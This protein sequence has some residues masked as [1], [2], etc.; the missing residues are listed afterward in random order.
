MEKKS[1]VAKNYLYN[2]GLNLL[3]M[4][5]PLIT[6]PYATRVIGAG[7]IGKVAFANSISNYFLMFAGLGISTYAIR[8][9]AKARDNKEKTDKI[10]SEIITINFISTLIFSMLYYS[11]LYM[12]VFRLNQNDKVLFSV[13]GLV[14]VLNFINIDW[15]YQGFEQYKYITIRSLIFKMISLIFLFLMVRNKSDYVWYAALSIIAQSGSNILNVINARKFVSF[16]MHNINLKKHIKPVLIIF[17]MGLAINVYNNLDSTIL[18]VR[19][20]EIYV[21]YYTAAVKIN[22]IVISVVT[23]L[24]VVLLPRLS[25]YIEND[26]EKF[27]SLIRKS[28][29]YVLFITI[30]SCIGLFILAPDIIILFSGNEFKP[31]IECMRINIPVIMFVAIANITSLQILLPL[32]KE[33]L[34]MVT[35]IIAALINLI[36]NFI[37]IPIYKQNGAAFSSCIAE[38]TVT[39]LQIIF[40]R[41]YI[42]KSILNKSNLNYIVGSLIIMIE[43]I[44]ISKL[45][46][47]GLVNLLVSISVSAVTYGIYLLF[48]KDEMLIIILRKLNITID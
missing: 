13:V 7:G 1:S 36:L 34:V 12:N 16:N 28:I 11:S 8:E 23:S 39:I 9:I 10:F 6:F 37:F 29:K 45:Q 33:K 14:L 5:F 30:P 32:R 25:Y 2:I 38:M 24:G 43:L 42:S 4:L 48:R 40:C 19:A 3:T 21:G 22:R 15:L 47:N 31:A 18:G 20:G 26:V 17:F 46:L 35:N 44:V 41:K 27:R